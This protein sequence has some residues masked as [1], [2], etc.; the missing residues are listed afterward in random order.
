MKHLNLWKMQMRKTTFGFVVIMAVTYSNSVFAMGSPDDA[1]ENAGVPFNGDVMVFCNEE[2]NYS[3]IK[4]TESS[5]Y[6]SYNGR[7][8]TKAN[9]DDNSTKALDT[10]SNYSI[11]RDSMFDQNYRL[12]TLKEL[13]N[14][15]NF[16]VYHSNGKSTDPLVEFP[17]VG[18]WF[19]NASYSPSN[20]I[21][22]YVDGYLISSTYKEDNTFM[23]VDI[24]SREIVA[25]DILGTFTDSL[26]VLGV[27]DYFQV[28][29]SSSNLCLGFDVDIYNG[30]AGAYATP[31]YEFHTNASGNEDEVTR[32]ASNLIRAVSCVVDDPSQRWYLNDNKIYLQNRN[33]NQ[34]CLKADTASLSSTPAD[35]TSFDGMSDKGLTHLKSISGNYLD[36]NS[37]NTQLTF[38]VQVT[39]PDRSWFIQY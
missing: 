12:P 11:V 1:V 34:Y 22:N 33:V 37:G 9:W 6:C 29:E 20:D 15:I 28:L 3:L 31:G 2:Q 18:N 25:L 30:R 13:L 7:Y 16:D 17:V 38:E 39:E 23:A 10:G 24:R 32:T 21:T 35:C 26:Y 19:Q 4:G 27:R 36:K 14:F 5:H 8:L